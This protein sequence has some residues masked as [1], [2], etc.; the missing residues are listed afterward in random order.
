MDTSRIPL[1][2]VVGIPVVA[3]FDELST[4][5]PAA[6]RRLA[7]IAELRH[8]V[9]VELSTDLGDGHYHEVLGLLREVDSAQDLPLPASVAV[10][11]PPGEWL[12]ARHEGPVEAIG[13]TF[14]ELI[15][16]ARRAGRRPSGE[17]LDIGY[18]LDGA[19]ESHELRIRVLPAEDDDTVQAGTAR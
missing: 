17:K 2:A 19:A 18:R 12:S 4:L 1:S 11:V 7:E 5:V 13:D 14:G 3:R 16:A 8:E 9:F 15:D 10:L 6:W